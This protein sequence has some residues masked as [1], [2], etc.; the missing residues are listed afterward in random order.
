MKSASLPLAKKSVK[1]AFDSSDFIVLHFQCLFEYSRLTCS[2]SM[3]KRLNIQLYL[4]ED[5]IVIKV[6]NY[7]HISHRSNIHGSFYSI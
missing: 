2:M 6:H 3:I 4:F 5:D 7:R 1:F